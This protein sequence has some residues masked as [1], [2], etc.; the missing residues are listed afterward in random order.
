MGADVVVIGGGFAGIAAATKLAAAGRRVVLVEKKPFLGGRAYSFRNPKTGDWLD[1]G[2][3]ALIGCYHET[4]KLLRRLDT[5]SD[6][7]LQ[8]SLNIT[9]RG[10][11]GFYDRLRCPKMPGPIHLAAGL[12]GMSS[13]GWRDLWA[14]FRLR[15]ALWRI[16]PNESGET[17]S[18]FCA[19]LNQPSALQHLMWDAITLSALN[20][21]PEK[22]DAGLFQEVLNLAFLGKARHTCLGVPAVPLQEL[23][24]EK[25]V[26]FLQEREGTVRL[27]DSVERLEI[28]EGKVTKAVLRSGENLSCAACI[29]AV[30]ERNLRAIVERSGL[31]DRIHV[32]HLGESPILSVYLQYERPFS[33]DQVCCLQGGTFEW[34]FH[35]SNFMHSG[36]Q[37]KYTVC[38]IASAARRLKSLK[39]VELVQAAVQDI[40]T[41]YPDS[42][43][44]EPV[45][46]LVFWEPWATFSA[47]PQNV[48]N[49]PGHV[50]SISN[51]FR[52][53]DWTDTGL[54]ATIEGAALSGHR[55]AD[56]VI[57]T[58]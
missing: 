36:E 39:R 9:Y 42:S 10:P 44:L 37:G 21:T 31:Q 26:R 58:S 51:F 53:G 13:M 1:N 52:A 49:R 40:K 17:V 33:G 54:P 18:R 7:H 48:R 57:L 4:F 35:R 28:K 6:I 8:D 45:T 22:A 15:L 27:G 25:A 41:A 46:A 24:G 3:H 16:R 50:T 34:V 32:P 43:P 12:L 23:H 56:L 30:P 19:R 2:Q 47:T 29:S 5:E 14:S 20:E 11:E 38:L 55:C